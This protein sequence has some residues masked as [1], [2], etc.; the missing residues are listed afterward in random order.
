MSS[1]FCQ[2]FFPIANLVAQII[3]KAQMAIVEALQA[4][5]SA[6]HPTRIQEN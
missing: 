5:P 6:P 4:H 1:F 3:Q 2:N